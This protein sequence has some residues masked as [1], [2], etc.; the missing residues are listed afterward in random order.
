MTSLTLL[1][2]YTEDIERLRLF[3]EACGLTMNEE[4]HDDGPRHYSSVLSSGTVFELYPGAVNDGRLGLRVP[5]LDR[6]LDAMNTGG[7]RLE[8][9][10]ILRDGMRYIVVKDPDGRRVELSESL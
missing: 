2:L 10:P 9:K 1:V 7:N 3:Y 6:A 8:G 4:Q 5:S